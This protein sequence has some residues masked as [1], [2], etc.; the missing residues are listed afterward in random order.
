MKHIQ[1]F[2]SFRSGLKELESKY[3]QDKES[4]DYDYSIKKKNFFSEKK[5]IVEDAL[6][7]L[8]EFYDATYE[9]DD[10]GDID[11]N[12]FMVYITIHFD[13]KNIS[14]EVSSFMNTLKRFK[15]KMVDEFK[16]EFYYDFD[17]GTKDWYQK[18]DPFLP[19]DTEDD[20]LWDSLIAV[21]DKKVISNDLV[22]RIRLE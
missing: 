2:E 21:R 5:K 18:F 16:I 10:S 19:L 9:L 1:L 13:E 4:L 8:I 17:K 6:P 3:R 11:S 7:E 22:I 14:Q 12:H 20:G 15:N